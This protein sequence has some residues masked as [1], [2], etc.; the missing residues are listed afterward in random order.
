MNVLR[1]TLLLLFSGICIGALLLILSFLLPVNA[2]GSN[3]IRSIEMVNTEGW[4]PIL[5]M[6]NRFE[7]I[8]TT[9]WNSAGYLDNY[10][11]SIMLH[12]AADD[13]EGNV[14]YRAMNMYNQVKDEGYSYYWH[15][16]VA[17]L[18]PLLLFMD[19]GDM[20][21]L[22]GLLQILLSVLLAC[23]V[24]Q[25]KGIVWLFLSLTIY[26][27]LMPMTLMFSMQYSW[28]FYVGTIGS[29]V[30]IKY[31]DWLW[32]KKWLIYLFLILGMLSSYLDLLTYPLFTWGI[33]MLWWVI[34]SKDEMAERE[35]LWGVISCG[36]YWIIGYGGMWAGKWILGELILQK[37]LISQ[38]LNEVNFRAGMQE[39]SPNMIQYRLST[40]LLNFKPSRNTQTF[41]MLSCW[42]LWIVKS[43]LMK[44]EKLHPTRACSLGLIGVSSFV[45]YI[46]LLNHTFHHYTFTYRIFVVT[47][48]AI[49]AMM[50]FA[51]DQSS[52]RSFSLK[53]LIGLSIICMISFIVPFLDKD[54]VFAHNGYCDSEVIELR[55]G[56][57]IEQVFTPTYRKTSFINLGLQTE[58][59]GGYHIEIYS[60]P[61]DEC[62]LQNQ[63]IIFQQFITGSEIIDS[64]FAEI[65]TNLSF[66]KDQTYIIRITVG[67]TGVLGHV[68]VTRNGE[69]PL[70]EFGQLTVNGSPLPGQV[71]GGINYL[72][73]HN[74][75]PFMMD[76]YA[77]IGIFGAIFLIG[78]YF[79]ERIGRLQRLPKYPIIFLKNK[80]D[81]K[82]NP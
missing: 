1:N 40:I 12:T 28:V 13:S 43:L 58:E 8:G 27:L 63:G 78:Y 56:D 51:V 53:K 39:N 24:Y 64:G 29:I 69:A 82:H 57:Y 67:G 7:R 74:K 62:S 61:D 45:W 6:I 35:R 72:K 54:Q 50:I 81:I 66:T 16:Y 14:L 20:R 2:S 60:K 48:A 80:S 15:G 33:P 47:F 49:L 17:I 18:R 76:L 3:V 34:F 36:I 52:H 41:V 70:M 4:Y 11:D 73:L 9:V 75:L 25:K 77:G 42:F 22:N 37:D 19:Y 44:K 71:I 26:G 32:K 23:L 5:P 46:V 59:T 31:G 10:T 65:P 55:E 38:A 30:V 21:V 68:T 79:Y